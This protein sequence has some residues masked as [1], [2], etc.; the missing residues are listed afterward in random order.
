MNNTRIFLSYSWRNK[1]EADII[2]NDFN[3]LGI[4]LIRDIRNLKYRDSLKEF[5]SSIKISDFV[6]IFVSKDFFC[7][8]NCMFEVSEIFESDEFATKI[9][10]VI[11]PNYDFLSSDNKIELIKFWDNKILELNSKIK[12]VD[13]LVNIDSLIVQ[14]NHFNNIR[15]SLD[16]VMQL[17]SDM[18][19]LT[20]SDLRKN[21]YKEI[22]ASIGY[23]E[24]KVSEELLR[25]NDLLEYDEKETQLRKL[26]LNYPNHKNILY[27]QINVALKNNN[28]KISGE[29]C[30]EYLKLYPESAMV[31]NNYSL[32]LKRVNNDYDLSRKHSLKAI[33]ID[34]Q[35][36]YWFNLGNLYLENL[37]NYEEAESCYEEAINL[38][39]NYFNA[40]EA[41]GYLYEFKLILL[42]KAESFYKSAFEINPESELIVSR[43]ATFYARRQEN[44]KA[45]SFYSK[46]LSLNP[47]S[48]SNH[49]NYALFLDNNKREYSK[50]R[51][52]FERAL[53]IN[54]YYG[55]AHFAYAQLL[56]YNYRDF[57]KAEK[58]L[59]IAGMY[60]EDYKQESF[61]SQIKLINS[62]LSDENKPVKDDYN[63]AVLTEEFATAFTNVAQSLMTEPTDWIEVKHN[64]LTLLEFHPKYD[65]ARHTLMNIL[66][67]LGEYDEGFKHLLILAEHNNLPSLH[68]EIGSIY[69]NHY[70]DFNKAI[71]HYNK[72]ID[73][74][75]E[76]P[77]VHMRLSMLHLSKTFEPKLAK[78]HYL[79]AC[80]QES[81]CIITE[82]DEI[83]E[84][85]RK[86]ID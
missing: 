13:T 17:F 69:Q 84:I 27:S 32:V 47:S 7:S 79:K 73:L 80:E 81:Q 41:L 26:L 70:Q 85:N 29:R 75:S 15:S 28:Y 56:L 53:E 4:N 74:Y 24:K 57:E 6:I 20:F 30:E 33:E 48:D 10:P 44:K 65:W 49:Y 16:K 21:D 12:S 64:L 67:M 76:S 51:T 36:V 82:L 40:Y 50:A 19:S 18:N 3:A 42:D 52:Y 71:E 60:V 54:P 34:P 45:D 31:H 8:E 35:Y 77:G 72:S 38:A 66:R 11:L 86:V 62:I 1:H 58:H 61:K 23:S 25:I 22:L 9:L 37:N 68:N 55:E 43:L 78:E 63:A 46:L 39:P 5:M 83:F 14:L 2:D 59:Q